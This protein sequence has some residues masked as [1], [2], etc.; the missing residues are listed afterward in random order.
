M[1][2]GL[3]PSTIQEALHMKK[4]FPNAVIYA[5]GSDLM[6]A[7]KVCH[8]ML[9]INQLS[10]LKMVEEKDE[11]IS[12]GAAAIYYDL[13]QNPLI[14]KLLK[15]AIRDIASPAIRNRATIGGNI[16][17]ASPAGDSLPILYLYDARIVLAS[18]DE[19]NQITE[20]MIPIEKFILGVRRID[21]KADEIL[22]KILLPKDKLV[23]TT[24]VGYKKVGARKAQAISKLLFAAVMNVEDEVVTDL[25]VAFGSVGVTVIRRKDM[26]ARY[27]GIKHKD[28]LSQIPEIIESYG[29]CIHPIDDQ[30]ST[31]VYRKKVCLNLLG[32]FL[33]HS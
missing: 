29:S 23:E 19:K 25:R 24:K 27:I 20:R 8:E 6:V 1:V 4:L 15:A 3:T 22:T 9:F 31:A 14:P 13:L 21:L 10:E 12:I 17:N 28:L 7:K 32:D 2:K 26:E 33:S 16:C 30:R 18:L 11:Y 5:G